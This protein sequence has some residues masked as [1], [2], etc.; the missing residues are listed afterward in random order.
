MHTLALGLSSG[1]IRSSVGTAP[2]LS[3]A[4]AEGRGGAVGRWVRRWD[5]SIGCRAHLSGAARAV[6]WGER[7]LSG[8]GQECREGTL[9]ICKT[10]R[11]QGGWVRAKACVPAD[12]S[13]GMSRPQET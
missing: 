13:S 10:A 6:L 5:V 1:P 2:A 8:Q 11:A 12:S 4:G 3:T 7:G 9:G